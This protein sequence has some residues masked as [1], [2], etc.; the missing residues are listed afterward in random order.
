M[1]ALTHDDAAKI[2]DRL[3]LKPLPVEGGLFV[4]TWCNRRGSE[5]VGTA[6]FAA[7]TDDPDSF[8]AMHRLPVDEVWHFYLGDP[9][10][11]LLLHQD[12]SWA[13]PHLGPD[14]LAGQHPQFVVPAGTWMGGRLCPGGVFALFGNTMAPG[15]RSEC[16]EGGTYEELA[17]RW[18][19]AAHSIESLVRPD[20]DLVMPA[21]M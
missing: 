19:A 18:P 17:A 4:Q 6:T 14:V 11:L 20:D 13:T 10:E 8:S 5:V 2:I 1:S 16:Y 9:V 7:F 21:G 3:K 15:F 12:G